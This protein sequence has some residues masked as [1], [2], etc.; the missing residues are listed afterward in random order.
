MKKIALFLAALTVGI[1][2]IAAQ[3]QATTP[4]K[5]LK[6]ECTEKVCTAQK[7]QCTAQKAQCAAQ[8]AECTHNHNGKHV[9]KHDSVKCPSTP[10][11]CTKATCKNCKD[12]NAAGN[13]CAKTACKD[14]TVH[15]KNK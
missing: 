6:K 9:C 11:K 1:F 3:Q 12:C 13:N 15:C 5:V 8:K 10:A 7:A 2:T 4:K 14:C